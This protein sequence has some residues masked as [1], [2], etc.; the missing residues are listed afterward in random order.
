MFEER[1]RRKDGVG[2]AL[3]ALH[4][5]KQGC[6]RLL[7]RRHQWLRRH[8]RR[9]GT[10]ER[11]LRTAVDA[12]PGGAERRLRLLSRCHSRPRRAERPLRP[13]RSIPSRLSRLFGLRRRFRCARLPRSSTARR[14]QPGG[15]RR[16]QNSRPNGSERSAAERSRKGDLRSAVSV[17][18]VEAGNSIPFGRD[19]TLR[20]IDTRLDESTDGDPVSVLVVESDLEAFGLSGKANRA[21]SPTQGDYDVHRSTGGDRRSAW[22]AGPANLQRV[23]P[24][25]DP[26]LVRET[27]MAEREIQYRLSGSVKSRELN[28]HG[29][30]HLADGS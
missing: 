4:R 5:R 29:P 27:V 20:V 26:E 3:D 19:R 25:G 8:I 28:G 23:R 17:I 9:P 22:A 16:D 7:Q 15:Y 21:L 12:L 11:R 2:I 18:V 30:L 1:H 14:E 10:D 24:G 13:R 6:L